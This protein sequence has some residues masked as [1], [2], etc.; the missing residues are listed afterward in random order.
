MKLLIL[1]SSHTVGLIHV[2]A[3]TSNPNAAFMTQQH[4]HGIL[5]NY[6]IEAEAILVTHATD[7][8]IVGFP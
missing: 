3:E 1:A 6:P 2:H 7:V 8:T 4:P 5:V